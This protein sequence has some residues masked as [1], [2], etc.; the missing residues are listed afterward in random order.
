MEAQTATPTHLGMLS[1][2]QGALGMWSSPR[3][4]TTVHTCPATQKGP[5]QLCDN[6][7]VP[8]DSPP[9]WG[10]K[11]DSQTVD[12]YGDTPE[13]RC[14]ARSAGGIGLPFPLCGTSGRLTTEENL[15]SWLSEKENAG[16]RWM[17]GKR[18]RGCHSWLGVGGCPPG[19]RRPLLLPS[20]P[21]WPHPQ[22]GAHIT[23]VSREPSL[24]SPLCLALCA[25]LAG[26]GPSV[27]DLATSPLWQR[28][29][30]GGGIISSKR[31]KW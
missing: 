16:M 30:E 19:S 26:Q 22:R 5:C 21:L 28:V 18:Q 3:P 29:R 10:M 11:G 15:L 4:R 25:R 7:Q 17:V 13:Q 24:H 9:G 6:T 12:C 1:A 8:S 20:L 23:G 14:L 2:D 27:R 31:R